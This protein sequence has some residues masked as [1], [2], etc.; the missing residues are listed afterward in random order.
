M[1]MLKRLSVCLFAVLLWVPTQS[2]AITFYDESF[3]YANQAALHASWPPSLGCSRTDPIHM[4][5]ST[6]RAHSGSKSL[7]FT[8]IGDASNQENCWIDKSYPV[9]TE[10]YVRWWLFLDGFTSQFPPTKHIFNGGLSQS[11]ADGGYPNT[12]IMIEDPQNY[13]SL[14]WQGGG[15]NTANFIKSGTYPVGRWTCVEAHIRMNTPDVADGIYQTWVDGQLRHN[16]T[17]MLVRRSS[18]VINNVTYNTSTGDFNY[19][20]LYRQ[21]GNGVLYID[22]LAVGNT[23]IEC[24]G[25]SGPTDTVAPPVPTG[26][27]VNG[28]VVTYNAVIDNG[29]PASGT[30]DYTIRRD[31]A[32]LATT[33]AT[34]YTDTTQVSGQSYVYD[35]RANDNAGNSSPFSAP[36]TLAGA[37]TSFRD[38]A[39]VADDFNRADNADLGAAYA[40]NYASPA[41][42]N[43]MIT[44]NQV[45]A[46]ALNASDPKSADIN[47]TVLPNDQWCKFTIPV[48]AGSED[49]EFGCVLRAN[50]PT[51]VGWYWGYIRKTATSSPARNA[52]IV[53]QHVG[54]VGNTNL[55]SDF[56]VVGLPGDTYIFEAVGTQLRLKRIAVGTSTEITLLTVAD[57][58]FTSGRCGIL[59]W[60]SNTGG[61]LADATL[62]DF[63][64]G[65]FSASA[66]GLIT[67][68]NISQSA[69]TNTTNTITFDHTKGTCANCVLV[70]ETQARDDVSAADVPVLTVTANGAALTKVRH[71]R[72]TDGTANIGTE[73]WY[74]LNPQGTTIP[75]TVT[76]TGPLSRF[77]VAS[78]KT[79]SGVDQLS[80]IDAQGGGTGT[81]GTVTSSIT[82]VAN[83]AAIVDTF[84]SR[85]ASSVTV[86]AG[87]VEQV[88]R[89]LTGIGHVGSSTVLNKTPAGAETMDWTRSGGTTWAH[90][91]VSFKPATVTP[92]VPPTIA[93]LTAD[94]TGLN[95]TFGPTAPT[96][97]RIVRGDNAG[98][99]S[100]ETP[101]TVAT[102]LVAGRYTK[103]GGWEAGLDYLGV[104]PF[105]NAGIENAAPG[106]NKFINNISPPSTGWSPAIRTTPPVLSEGSQSA[107]ILPF[108][109]GT[110][111]ISFTMDVGSDCRYHVGTGNPVTDAAVTYDQMTLQ[112]MVTSLTASASVA[113]ADG[114]TNLYYGRCR[115]TNALLN[116]FDSESS[117]VMT[118]TVAAAPGD[119]TLPSTITNLTCT[120]DGSC[121]WPSATDNVAVRSYRVSLSTDGCATL[122]FVSWPTVNSF[123]FPVLVPGIPY[124]VAVRAED[125]SGNLSAADS[126]LYPFTTL[127]VPDVTPPSDMI[128]LR[129]C[130]ILTAS[131]A[132]C[133]NAPT[134]DRGV[135]STTIQRCQGVNCTDFSDAATS[136][137]SSNVVSTGLIAGT[138][139]RFRGF[140]SD[141]TNNSV[142]FSN[143]INVTTA[144]AGIGVGRPQLQFGQTRPVPAS[145]R[146]V[147][148][149]PRPEADPCR[150]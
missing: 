138:V 91:S 121:V 13:L 64:C 20:R 90:S 49:R 51:A 98:N 73:L 26:L 140:H 126:N 71:D 106:A 38:V 131:V 144:T 69:D 115:Y 5:V 83:N 136:S 86:G 108:G 17:N 45:R 110:A 3:E 44:S 93:S 8:Y 7:K 139:N 57:A 85:A 79:L 141:G 14:A 36:V 56:S 52:A 119:T 107:S 150:E 48:W 88:N 70:V 95:V 96:T 134:D 129:Q 125:S 10:I 1:K 87:Q 118:V 77:G 143:I 28:N 6:A 104:R 123:T 19:T 31:A 18:V 117:I 11:D 116:S 149:S 60:M 113:V 124:C 101:I 137:L 4:E 105:N 94:T 133:F 142:N 82:T 12:W 147:P 112:M 62:D 89:L 97:I 63:S 127:P 78:A 21:H 23:R 32:I 9:G 27:A 114:T 33:T 99:F 46:T 43:A 102:D 100:F 30:R 25:A 50:A 81:S 132:L 146:P 41:T 67:L 145:P 148:S 15:G 59:L 74:L 29:N 2:Y 111:T 72:I 80:P 61:N 24:G 22:Q 68:D 16:I 54:A 92:V 65:G 76:W 75:I 103:V 34:S 122:G 37:A 58:E 109:V 47:S 53:S 40:N 128:N 55:A 84:F 130:G 42:V 35:V 135:T 39:L 120:V 66:A